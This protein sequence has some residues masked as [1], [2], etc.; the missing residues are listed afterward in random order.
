MTWAATVCEV[1]PALDLEQRRELVVL[2]LELL[3]PGV[4]GRA[5]AA[6]SLR[7]RLVVVRERVDLPDRRD[8]RADTLSATS[9][10]APWTGRKANADAALE[11]P[12][13]QG[14]DEKTISIR[15]IT[16]STT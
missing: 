6:F 14:F 1:E 15:L 2:A 16:S 10:I 3:G 13:M 9:S 8:H 7:Q 12:T 11:L 5:G 4:L